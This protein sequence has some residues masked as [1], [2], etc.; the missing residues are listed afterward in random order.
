VRAAVPAD[1]LEDLELPAGRLPCGR[2]GGLARAESEREVILGVYRGVVCDECL[3]DLEDEVRQSQLRSAGVPR[4]Y[5]E[6]MGKGPWREMPTM[7]PWVLIVGPVGSGKTHAAVEMLVGRSASRF[8]AWPEVVELR[9]LH[10]SAPW[11]IEDPL[12]RLRRMAG[13][14]L[15]DDLGAEKVTEESR[16]AAELLFFARYNAQAPTIITSNLDLKALAGAYGE[17]V[18][19]RISEMAKVVTLAERTDRRRAGLTAAKRGAS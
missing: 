3:P 9:R 16:A 5:L 12:S 19:S 14:L 18:V 8:A 7:R 13:V 15:L 17:K 6:K 2:C 11:N 10:L 4:L 1:H